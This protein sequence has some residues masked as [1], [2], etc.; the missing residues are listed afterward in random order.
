MIGLNRLPGR[1][2]AGSE[3]KVYT[4]LVDPQAGHF[5]CDRV[6]CV[7]ALC[8]LATHGACYL[9]F[10]T[11]GPVQQRSNRFA[12][13]L[14]MATAVVCIPTTIATASVR[15]ALYANLIARPWTWVLAIGY[16]VYLFRSFRGKVQLEADAR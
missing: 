12:R 4:Y 11:N 2:S 15:P 10:K 13:R 16:F 6:E 1:H 3:L 14:A 9:A 7:F 8:A 5:V